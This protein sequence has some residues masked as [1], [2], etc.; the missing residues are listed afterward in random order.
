MRKQMTLQEALEAIKPGNGLNI[1]VE[2]EAGR[3]ADYYEAR[4]VIEKAVGFFQELEQFGITIPIIQAYKAFEDECIRDGVT[5]DQ[6]LTLKDIV[7]G[8]TC[9]NCRDEKTCAICD[10]FNIKYCSDMRRKVE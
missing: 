2:G 3:I 5:F 4:K 1:T 7:K 8:M 10:N 6:I 9:E